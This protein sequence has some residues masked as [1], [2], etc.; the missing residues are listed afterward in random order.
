MGRVHG[1]ERVTTH[2]IGNKSAVSKNAPSFQRIIRPEF[3]LLPEKCR[4]G[5]VFV[6]VPIGPERF[7]V[8]EPDDFAG[9]GGSDDA[10]R[11]ERAAEAGFEGP[12]EFRQ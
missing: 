8:V 6:P 12:T 2:K 10:D 7:A 4:S 5:I 9:F 3:V 11:V 1:A